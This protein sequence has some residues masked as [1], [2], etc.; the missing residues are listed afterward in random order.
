MKKSILIFFLFCTAGAFY[1]GKIFGTYTHSM[2]QEARYPFYLRETLA[3]NMPTCDIYKS[4]SNSKNKLDIKVLTD[5][6]QK[7]AVMITTAENSEGNIKLLVSIINAQHE[8][9]FDEVHLD[10]SQQFR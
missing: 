6:H 5:D 2:M 3:K 1:I 4:I 7:R 10:C 8:Q 9:F